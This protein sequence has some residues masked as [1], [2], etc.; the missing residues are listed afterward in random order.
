MNDKYQYCGVEHCRDSN[1][2]PHKYNHS[3]TLSISKDKNAHL[4]TFHGLKKSNKKKVP[5]EKMW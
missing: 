4:K 5:C 3:I 2:E 1:T